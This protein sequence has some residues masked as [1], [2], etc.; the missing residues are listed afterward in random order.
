MKIW[1]GLPTSLASPSR[2]SPPYVCYSGEK[3]IPTCCWYDIFLAAPFSALSG[4]KM[5]LNPDLKHC[6]LGLASFSYHGLVGK[7]WQTGSGNEKL[8]KSLGWKLV[9]SP[10]P[11]IHTCTRTRAHTKKHLHKIRD[12]LPLEINPHPHPPPHEAAAKNCLGLGVCVCIQK[13]RQN[14]IA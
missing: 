13:R 12:T 6:L 3:I 9:H 1:L 4:S 8:R 11:Q 14:A 7:Q 5:P 2:L 10:P